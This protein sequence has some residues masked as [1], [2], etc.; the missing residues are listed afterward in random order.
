MDI[1]E[2]LTNKKSITSHRLRILL[3]QHGIFEDKCQGC[4]IT[5][6]CNRPI[7]LHLH[8]IDGNNKNNLLSNLNVLCPNCHSKTNNYVGKNKKRSNR[9]RLLVSDAKL[10][11]CIETSCSKREALLKAGLCGYG[12]SYIRITKVIEQHN[13]SFKP[14][15][16]NQ[17]R[18]A[19]KTKRLQTIIKKYG[20]VQNMFRPTKINWPDATELEK[21]LTVMPCSQVAKKLGVSDSSVKKRAK[22][23]GI[24]V[25]EISIWAK[26]HGRK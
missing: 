8:H 20:T 17:A 9:P 26:K 4:G 21:M 15:P 6:W 7:T 1:Q 25:R 14:R 2:Y 13:L 22:H 3:I 24:N 10:I 23:Y 12:G 5:N 18:L 16:V 19:E 11:E